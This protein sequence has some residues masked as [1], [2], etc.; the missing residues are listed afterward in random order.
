MPVN[1]D[2]SPTAPTASILPPGP[3]LR[4]VLDA[5]G[6]AL[7]E[8]LAAPCGLGT[9][10]TDV[11]ILDPEDQP[12]L[13]RGELAL[14]V[15]ARGRAA[16]PAVRL[17]G[18]CGAS[19]VAVKHGPGAAPALSDAATGAGVALLRV[20]PEARWER[21]EGLIRT[22]IEL[23]R[24]TADGGGDAAAAGDLAALAQTVASLTGGAVTIEDTANRV[25]AYSRS[26]DEVDELRRLSILGRQGPERYLAMLRDWGVYRRL[27]EAEGVVGVDERPDLG[28]RRRIAAGIHAGSRPLGTI[29]V[30]EGSRP[31]T[32]QAERALLGATRAAAP[33]LVRQRTGA[34]AGLPLRENLLA[35][36]L[37]G[38]LGAGEVADDIGADTRQP[39]AVAAFTLEPGTPGAGTERQLDRAE[40][41]NLI[42]VHAAAYRRSALVS[43]LGTRVYV[44]LPD[45]PQHAKP[46]LTALARDVVSAAGSHLRLPVLAAL[47]S[48]VPGL[49]DVADSRDD[50]DR[51]L[52]A[53]AREP[54]P[55][56]G[57]ARSPRSPTSNPRCCCRNCWR[58]SRSTRGCATPG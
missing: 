31:L 3:S 50:A 18:R 23:V 13:H 53:M 30:Q 38:A 2:P 48:V 54:P 34:A 15:G 28:I 26:S 14:V 55:P 52:D 25:L 47:G 29:W 12:E 1:S 16:I 35:S 45:L 22:V 17:A 11:V 42:S 21:V 56:G 7:A 46:G 19:A 51:V 10:V 39:A 4:R 20:P 57:T 5:L 37:T 36:L 41:V 27:R 43:V 49:A 40:L 24:T 9:E 44:L 58:C 32:E 8:V 6:D 33:L